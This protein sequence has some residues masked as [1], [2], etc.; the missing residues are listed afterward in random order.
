[1]VAQP[2][3]GKI[4]TYWNTKYLFLASF[5]VFEIGSTLCAAAPN[6]VILIVGRAVAGAGYGGLYTGALMIIVDSVPLHRRPLYLS[7][8][9]SMSA[10][11]C[12]IPAW[13][14]LYI[15]GVTVAA[16]AGPLLG[17]IFTDSA[18]LKWRFAFWINLRRCIIQICRA[19]D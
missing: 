13:S 9:G 6:S 4:Y 18:K 5:L 10:G 7:L 19:L 2:T 16:V 8:V 1:M 14:K 12:V 15:N 11:M 17:G 3:L